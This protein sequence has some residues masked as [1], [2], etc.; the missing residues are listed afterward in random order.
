MGSSPIPGTKQRIKKSIMK[1]FVT[2]VLQPEMGLKRLI[3]Y[4]CEKISIT[5]T[6]PVSKAFL[7]CTHEADINIFL[8]AP[9]FVQV[10]F[11]AHFLLSQMSVKT[12]VHIYFTRMQWKQTCLQKLST[13]WDILVK[14]SQWVLR[15]YRNTF[16]P[17][18]RQAC[19]SVYYTINSC[20]LFACAN[21]LPVREI[22]QA[23]YSDK[24]QNEFCAL[25]LISACSS[26]GRAAA[27]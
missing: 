2:I 27:S 17:G 12:K 22:L 3:R 25:L 5:C 24:I 16:S 7:N 23:G 1:L 15:K 8:S 4:F 20:L 9:S 26:V 21:Y 10:R 6:E 11:K 14:I 13:H 18:T 19:L